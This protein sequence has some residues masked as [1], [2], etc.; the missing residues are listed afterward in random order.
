MGIDPAAQPAGLPIEFR[1]YVPQRDIPELFRTSSVLVMPYNSS[2]GSSG[3]AHQACEYGVPIVCADISDFR[4]MA[5]DDDMAISFYKVGDAADLADKLVAILQ[6]PE[7]QRQMAEHNYAGRNP[8]DDGE[9]RAQLP[10]LVRTPSV[11]T[12][13]R[14]WRRARRPPQL[15]APVVVA[16]LD[17]GLRPFCRRT[18]M[19][20]AS[21]EETRTGENG[22][23]ARPPGGLAVAAQT[24]PRRPSMR[25]RMAITPTRNSKM[26]DRTSWLAINPGAGASSGHRARGHALGAGAC[27]WALRLLF[28]GCGISGNL[29]CRYRQFDSCPQR[30]HRR[31]SGLGDSER[32][33]NP[34]RDRNECDDR[35]RGRH[36][37]QQLYY[38]AE[39]R[40]QTSA[41]PRPRPTPQPRPE[42]E[43]GLCYHDRDS[44]IESTIRA[45]GHHHRQS[46]SIAP[47]NSSMLTVAALNATQ[48]TVTG[49]DEQLYLAAERGNPGSQPGSNDDLY[50][51]R[52]GL[53]ER[54]GNHNF[55]GD[56][57]SGADRHHHCQSCFNRTGRFVHVGRN[58]DQR[59]SGDDH[60]DR[61][62]HL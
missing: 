46:A 33:C 59:H 40:T 38:A 5:V 18:R 3:P 12:H 51:D 31:E 58:H 57:E 14:R 41:Q 35:D 6:S 60:R 32:S 17:A 42:R 44:D 49:T 55:D 48:V 16:P 8:D 9:R 15:A 4:C 7:L 43:E 2:T 39:R 53:E 10:S 27:S 37:W 1:G 30:H 26:S 19:A 25:R 61:W 54:P 36:R 28:A 62:Q 21:L 45:D 23:G 52:D 20:S 22:D 47:G 34:H 13:D 56:R 24:A 29:P 11:Q 50:R